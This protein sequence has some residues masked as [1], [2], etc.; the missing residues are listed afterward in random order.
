MINQPPQNESVCEGGTVNFTCVV[1]FTS[2]RLSAAFWITNS[3]TTDAT[4]LPGHT[5]TDDSN[6]RFAPANVTTVLTVTNVNISDGEADYT[7]A[8]GFFEKKVIQYI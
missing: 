3:G 2:R 1:M 7:C 6:G 5:R 8:Q 4:T